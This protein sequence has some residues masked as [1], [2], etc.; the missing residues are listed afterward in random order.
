MLGWPGPQGSAETECMLLA[1]LMESDRN[2]T[3][4]TRITRCKVSNKGMVPT[5][6]RVPGGSST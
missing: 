4:S 6:A 5:S 2:G 3:A 1:R